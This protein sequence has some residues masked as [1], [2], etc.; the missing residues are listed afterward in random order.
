MVASNERS[1]YLAQGPLRKLT[2]RKGRNAFCLLKAPVR[3]IIAP[4]CTWNTALKLGFKPL[5]W[6]KNRDCFCGNRAETAG[7]NDHNWPY[8]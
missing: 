1:A 5:L 4:T 2:Q 6:I 7:L 8:S 3:N